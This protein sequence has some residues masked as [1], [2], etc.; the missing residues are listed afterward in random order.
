MRY[1]FHHIESA[2]MAQVEEHVREKAGYLESR[3]ATFQDDLVRLDIRLS[4]HAKRYADRRN[5]SMFTSHLVLDLP[6]RKLPNIGA[7]GHGETWTTAI[8][9][10]F[11]V[12]E[13]QLDKT[14]AKLQREAAI[15]AYRH[16]PSWEREGATLMG[17]PQ[18]EPDQPDGWTEE[19][20]DNDNG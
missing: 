5:A 13:V 2:P 17:K 7:D 4:R 19:W 9:Q 18:A 14:L 11:D 20:D 16:R 12:L 15:H 10:A 1:R 3:L 8:N 6:G